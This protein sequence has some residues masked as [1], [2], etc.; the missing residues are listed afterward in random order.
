MDTIRY[1]LPSAQKLKRK[2]LIEE[3]FRSGKQIRD[4]DL[5]LFYKEHNYK[6]EAGLQV[7]FSVSKRRFKKAV[8]RNRIKRLM[9]EAWRYEKLT[10]QDLLE[11]HQRKVII[12]LL[13]TGNQK[14]EQIEI[15]RKISLLLQE[16]Q[17]QLKKKFDVIL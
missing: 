8:D 16:L 1:T 5:L 3:L 10:L 4:S 6:V 13:F 14:P 12:M 15:K 9:R 2:K 11:K 7:G 17:V